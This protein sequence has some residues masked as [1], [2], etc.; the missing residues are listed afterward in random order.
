MNNKPPGDQSGGHGSAEL[1][2]PKSRTDTAQVNGRNRETAKIKKRQS[3][4]K[5]EW[6]RRSY[7]GEE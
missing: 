4:V 6:Q 1:E 5:S 2:E 3:Q 7:V